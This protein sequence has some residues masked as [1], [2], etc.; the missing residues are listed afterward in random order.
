M[1]HEHVTAASVAIHGTASYKASYKAARSK[2]GAC[3]RT[4][5]SPA[6][7]GGREHLPPALAA[8]AAPAPHPIWS[9]PVPQVLNVR[10]D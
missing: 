8:D 10:Q 3:P 6:R 5:V 1:G 4:L 2:Y 7:A 9:H